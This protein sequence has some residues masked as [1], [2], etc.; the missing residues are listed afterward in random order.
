MYI[1]PD[2]LL[3]ALLILSMVLLGYQAFLDITMTYDLRDR[4]E[5]LERRVEELEKILNKG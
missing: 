5:E 4:F 3:E 2:F 1:L